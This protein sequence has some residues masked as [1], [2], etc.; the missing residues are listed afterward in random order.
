MA[1]LPLAAEIGRMNMDYP[2]LKIFLDVVDDATPQLV[3]MSHLLATAGVSQGQFA[4][5]FTS[6]MD[7]TELLA[8]ECLQLDFL[9]PQLD[10]TMAGASRSVH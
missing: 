10:G 2:N 1:I 3:V 8:Q 9:F 4:D 5:F 7:A 6:T